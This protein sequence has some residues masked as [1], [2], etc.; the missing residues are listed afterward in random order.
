MLLLTAIVR[1]ASPGQPQ[2]DDLLAQSRVGHMG[3][4]VITLVYVLVTL[5]QR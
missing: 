5:W 4:T 1:L 2:S 3:L